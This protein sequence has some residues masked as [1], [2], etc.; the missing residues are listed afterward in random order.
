MKKLFLI[1]FSLEGSSTGGWCQFRHLDGFCDSPHVGQ[2]HLCLALVI[3]GTVEAECG[4]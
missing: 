2:P 3:T 1:L 4:M